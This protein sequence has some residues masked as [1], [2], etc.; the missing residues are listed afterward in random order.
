LER[1]VEEKHLRVPHQ[2]PTQGHPLALSS[3]H[4][5]RTPIQQRFDPQHAC[6]LPHSAI[7]FRL[8]HFLQGKGKG[9]VIVSRHVWVEGIVLEHHGDVPHASSE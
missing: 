7:D 1:L 4:L 5:A 8:P 2:C 3:R 6:S 9:E